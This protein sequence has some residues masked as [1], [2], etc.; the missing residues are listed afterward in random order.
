MAAVRRMAAGFAL[1]VAVL[2]TAGCGSQVHDYIADTYEHR[3]RSGDVD[4]YYSPD[5][6]GTTVSDIVANDDPAAR[7][8]DGGNE[9]L[10]YNDDIVTVGAA[11]GGGSTITVEDLD[12]R[13]SSGGFVF[14][15]PGFTPGSPAAGNT[16][17]GSGS[18][19]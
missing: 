12:G 9:Y 2:A 19:K 17:G 11:S 10:R 8:A 7:K 13:Y 1:V 6:V 3:G 15:G 5:P 4:T 16:S 18:A 14:L